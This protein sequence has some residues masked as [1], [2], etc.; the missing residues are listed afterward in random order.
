MD[1]IHDDCN[2]FA[3]MKDAGKNLDQNLKADLKY[4]H[5]KE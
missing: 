1:S 3:K 4:K 2:K 5:F